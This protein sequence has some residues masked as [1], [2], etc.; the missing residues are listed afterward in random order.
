[1]QILF[2]DLV[3]EGEQLLRRAEAERLGGLQI[4]DE[5]ELGRLFH[6][7]FGRLRPAQDL[8]DKIASAS[9]KSQEVRAIG[10]QPPC[11]HEL[12][13]VKHRRQPRAQRQ[14]GD[15]RPISGYERVIAD[16]KSLR[17]ALERRGWP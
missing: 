12:S 1:V 5:V 7:S 15:A 10:H 14:G 17:A 9:I 3:R 6:R 2:D 11:F 16:T 13:N 8:V 4:K